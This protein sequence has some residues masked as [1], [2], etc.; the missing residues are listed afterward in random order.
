MNEKL[1]GSQAVGRA[2]CGALHDTRA[3]ARAVLVPLR[4]WDG[5]PG[6]RCRTRMKRVGCE[7]GSPDS[8]ASIADGVCRG[9]GD[10]RA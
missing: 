9:V 3:A 2:A 5:P 8:G 4:T 10:C 7:P 1:R 6:A